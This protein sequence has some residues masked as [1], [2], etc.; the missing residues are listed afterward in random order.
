MR[1]FIVSILLIIVT[2]AGCSA[3]EEEV[4]IDTI[5]AEEVLSLDPDADIFQFDGVIY[6]T[7]IDWV[8]ELDLTK[9][10]QIGEIKKRNDTNTDFSDDMSNKLPVGTKIFSAKERGD[11]L[12]VE[13]YGEILKYLV[14]VEG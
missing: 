10:V 8:E 1:P 9:D 3:G 4:T 14:V 5:D 11:I 6:Q 12:L 7:N 2:V 13:F